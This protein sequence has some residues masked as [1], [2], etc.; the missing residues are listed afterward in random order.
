MR[1]VTSV[2]SVLLF[3]WFWALST[4]P[5][6]TRLLGMN[7][8]SGGI[9]AELLRTVARMDPI[10]KENTKQTHFADNLILHS[11]VKDVLQD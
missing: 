11:I 7:V 6:N 2:S 9:C 10:R 8:G 3:Y 4:A 1:E 5:F